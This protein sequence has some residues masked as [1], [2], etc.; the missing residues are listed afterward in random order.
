MVDDNG[1][2]RVIYFFCSSVS[3]LKD[4]D[5]SLH[6]KII[7][8]PVRLFFDTCCCCLTFT[9]FDSPTYKYFPSSITYNAA[10]HNCI[11]GGAR[12][13]ASTIIHLESTNVS[14]AT[15]AAYS[16]FVAK[17]SGDEGGDVEVGDENLKFGLK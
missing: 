5:L 2:P 6:E 7:I 10:V 11:L 9:F 16:K 8:L 13:P 14:F 15:L 3:Y 17:D 12:Q 4:S 1:T